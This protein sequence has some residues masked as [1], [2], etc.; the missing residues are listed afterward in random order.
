MA[1]FHW[2]FSGSSSRCIHAQPMYNPCAPQFP[3]TSPAWT[4][5]TSLHK[6]AE[7]HCTSLAAYPTTL[8]QNSPSLMHG[9]R[10]YGSITTPL[11]STRVNVNLLLAHGGNPGRTSSG[12]TL[13]SEIDRNDFNQ[14]PDG[15]KHDGAGNNHSLRSSLVR[16]G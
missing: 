13:T 10:F 1:P 6:S 11:H 4:Q 2:W 9:D 15:S 3:N 14:W 8:R 7:A 5:C 12:F 16:G